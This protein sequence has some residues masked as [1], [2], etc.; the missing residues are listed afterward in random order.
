ME[1]C[2]S[3]S[4]EKFGPR[5]LLVVV[6]LPALCCTSIST[7]V[8]V[9]LVKKKKQKKK[10]DSFLFGKPVQKIVGFTIIVLLHFKN[11]LTM[12]VQQISLW[13]LL[14]ASATPLINF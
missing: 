11:N 9:I 6:P 10:K 5:G 2:V 13:L 14:A 3:S 1:R 7:L 4:S 8:K 12:W